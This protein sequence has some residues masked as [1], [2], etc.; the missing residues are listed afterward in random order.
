MRFLLGVGQK[1]PETQLP[2]LK[3]GKI[4]SFQSEQPRAPDI[5]SCNHWEITPGKLIQKTRVE[6]ETQ[7][8]DA[9]AG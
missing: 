7:F 2:G 1:L 3:Y 6:M 4:A 9:V 8:Q 5:K